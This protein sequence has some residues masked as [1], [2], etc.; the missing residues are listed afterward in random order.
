MSENSAE[1]HTGGPPA[2]RRREAMLCAVLICAYFLLRL[3]NLRAMPV[4]CDEAT[5]IRW[6][7]LIW[8]DPARNYWVSMEDAKLPAHYWGLAIFS[9]AGKTLGGDPL[10]W[11]RLFSVLCGA[12]MIPL[13]FAIGREI[14]QLFRAQAARYFGAAASVVMI[15]SPLLADYQR[16]ALAEPLLLLESVALMWLSLRLARQSVQ[17]ARAR[18]RYRTGMLLGVAWAATLLTKQNFSYLLWAM[19][20]LVLALACQPGKRIQQARAWIGPFLAASAVGMAFFVPAVWSGTWAELSLKLFYKGGFFRV[21]AYSRGE[22]FGMNLASL[23]EPRVQSVWTWW[24]HRSASP[25]DDGMLYIYLT[26]PVMAGVIAGG[27]WLLKRRSFFPLVL[28]GAWGALLLGPVLVNYN[29]IK[30]RYALLGIFPLLLL[31]AWIIAEF[32]HA[33]IA[34][35]GRQVRMA[36]GFAALLLLA[37]PLASSVALL[38]DPAAAVRTRRDRQEYITEASAGAAIQKAVA[39]LRE[40]ADD[41]PITIIT[42]TTFGLENDYIW[43]MLRGHPNVQL[44]AARELPLAPDADGTLHLCTEQS[45]PGRQAAIRLDPARPVFTLVNGDPHPPAFRP[46]RFVC[47]PSIAQLAGSGNGVKVF[48]NPALLPGTWPA[49]GVAVVPLN[50]GPALAGASEKRD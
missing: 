44:L 32:L 25:L 38:H 4:F 41:H 24:P 1:I 6:A 37:W 22:V 49:S 21:P 50:G 46:E 2:G 43:L 34:R 26:P 29:W 47:N 18:S 3:P 19:P 39:W 20:L 48:E 42:G 36:A 13:F 8:D 23:F 9:G 33:H 12:A 5:Y 31:A 35:A 7:Q 30:T 40:Q 17:E 27:L 28:F 10:W 14:C 16:M 15:A 45:F 11:G